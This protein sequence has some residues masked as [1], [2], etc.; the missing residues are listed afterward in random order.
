MFDS[1]FKCFVQTV[2]VWVKTMRTAQVKSVNKRPQVLRG[3]STEIK[4]GKQ[5]DIEYRPRVEKRPITQIYVGDRRLHRPDGRVIPGES[6]NIEGLVCRPRQMNPD[7][8][9]HV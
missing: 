6:R 9:Y 5:N 8:N 2:G 4:M 7:S 1:T 3:L